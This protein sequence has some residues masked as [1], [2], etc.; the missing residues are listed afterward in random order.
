MVVDERTRGDIAADGD[1]P[2]PPATEVLIKE[3]RRRQRRRHAIVAVFV[4]GALGAASALIIAADSATRS[5]TAGGYPETTPNG[6]PV[7]T[8][9]TVAEL[10]VSDQGAVLGAGNEAYLVLVR[11]IG[12]RT[13]TLHGYPGVDIVAVPGSQPKL[14]V[15][16]VSRYQAFGL[17]AADAAVPPAVLAPHG[18]SASFWIAGVDH[19][20]SGSVG[21]VTGSRMLVTLPGTGRAMVVPLPARSTGWYWCNGVSVTPLLPGDS[22]TLPV[23]PLPYFFGIPRAIAGTGVG[24]DVPPGP[25]PTDPSGAG[26][27]PTS[28]P[29]RS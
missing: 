23:V 20:A 4:V 11:N 28:A 26:S 5:P 21:C 7:V 18:G 17:E 27:S 14:P 12:G 10:R 29:P 3:A 13:C 6:S 25:G 9:C 22:G 24:T 19:P 16:R 15:A 1:P 8:P 2:A